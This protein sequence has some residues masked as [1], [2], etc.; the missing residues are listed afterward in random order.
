MNRI[1]IAIVSHGHSQFLMS[2]N[3][4]MSV[5]G[6]DNVTLVV[7]D[8][9]SE[10]VLK[11]FCSQ[12]SIDYVYSETPLGFGENNNMVAEYCKNIGMES[13]DW[14]I[15]MNPDVTMDTTNFS[16][17][18]SFLS[19]ANGDFYTIN[20][21]KDTEYTISENSAR[22]YPNW[23]NLVNMVLRKP[24]T[25]SYPK[26]ELK[27]GSLIEWASG[28][29]LI[30]RARL[31]EQLGGFDRSYF[32]YYEDVDICYRAEHQVGTKLGFITSVKAVHEGAY[33]NRNP[34]SK[35]FWWYLR[36]LF[37]FLLRK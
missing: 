37:R 2:N 1:Y 28:A 8:N 6:R 25:Q 23:G 36:S 24:V 30:F 9:I 13:S 4:L 11:D 10:Q 22:Y 34:M 21:F 29:F 26:D 32:M 7:R 5:A 12:N 17:L 31:F 16:Q 27:D 14:F 3:E 18:A 15:T 20:L 33:K 19:S 35:H